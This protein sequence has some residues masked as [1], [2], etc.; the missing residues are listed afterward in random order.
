MK[1]IQ[2]KNIPTYKISVAPMLDWTDRHFRTF[3]RLI[4]RRSLFYTEMVAAPAVIL[5]NRSKLLDF[6][7]DEHPL[8][9][10]LGGSDPKMMAQCARYAEDWGYC[11]VNINAGCPSSRVQAGQ[12]GAVLMN[13]PEQ[14][15]ECVSNM[16]VAVSIPVTVK[17]RISL[18][19]TN[20]DG[21]EA[22]FN[23]AHLVKSAGCA[24][25]I[26]HA[27]KARLN[28]SPKDNRSERLPLNY[29]VVYRLK[30]SFP[31]MNIVMNGNILSYESIDTHLSAADGVMIGR[32]AYG[33]PYAM[34]RIDE[35]YYGDSHPI[36][37][38]VAIL[39]K[40]FPYLVA[41]KDK[42][43]IIMPHLMGLYHGQPNAK[44]YKQI[45]MSRDLEL[46]KDFINH[47]S[48]EERETNPVF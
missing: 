14:V 44:I 32:W 46:L 2:E 15:A 3:L 27:R 23:F 48:S 4:T 19:D 22:L 35:K 41:N 34:A 40:M 42:L 21:F 18:S 33:N 47:S 43:S 5:G 28:L 16:H 20:G 10:Q 37:S 29:D 25:L 36:L 26:V 30:K 45:L 13:K 9:L 7:T 38:R 6:S 8:A 39:E 24:R 12:F 17:T 1:N 31:D 11:E